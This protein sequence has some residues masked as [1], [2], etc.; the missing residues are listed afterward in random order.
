MGAPTVSPF[1]STLREWIELSVV[2]VLTPAISTTS[3]VL[4][5]GFSSWL[6]TQVTSKAVSTQEGPS[7]GVYLT[8]IT[9]L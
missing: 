4:E 3:S 5:G 9:K 1:S 2:V 7:K 8:P 6:S